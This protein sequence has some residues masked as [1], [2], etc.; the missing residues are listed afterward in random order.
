MAETRE[1]I[2]QILAR[3]FSEPQPTHPTGDVLRQSLRHAGLEL[4]DR[5]GP[6]PEIKEALRQL[7]HVPTGRLH[8]WLDWMH[9]SSWDNW[10]DALRAVLAIALTRIEELEA[11][12][13][14]SPP[15]AELAST[16]PEGCKAV[17]KTAD[18]DWFFYPGDDVGDFL[19]K[20]ADA[21][22]KKPTTDPEQALDKARGIEDRPLAGPY[23]G[24]ADRLDVPLPDGTIY[25]FKSKAQA[26]LLLKQLCEALVK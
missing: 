5:R 13:A 9:D 1:T 24:E 26:E 8:P 11:K 7:I 20:L 12:A 10:G 3:L 2:E 15:F 19:N 21:V 25:H 17:V 16:F 6:I 22:N 23:A 4:I 18:A 14:V